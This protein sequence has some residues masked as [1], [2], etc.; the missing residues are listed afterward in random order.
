MKVARMTFADACLRSLMLLTFTVLVAACHRTTTV[1]SPEPHQGEDPLNRVHIALVEKGK[2]ERL[3]VEDIPS[4]A[5]S[6]NPFEA[7]QTDESLREQPREK[8]HPLLKRWLTTR[9]MEEPELILINL[10]DD[11]TVPRFPEPTID[12]P[13]DSAANRKVKAEAGRLIDA[14]KRRRSEGY[15]RFMK[16]VGQRYHAEVLQTFWLVHAMLVKMPLGAVSALAERQDILYIQPAISGEEPPQNANNNDDVDD[17]RAR[18]VSDPYFN[19]GQTGG[20]IGLLDTGMRFTHTQLTSPSHVDFRRDCVNGGANCNTGTTLNPV[21]DCWDHGTSSGAI[22]TA[23]ANQGNVFRGV[24]GITLDSFKVYPTSFD[25]NGLCNGGL[26]AAAA[27][28]GFQTAVAVLDRVIVAEMQSGGTDTGAIS[29]AADNAFDAGAVIIAAN[30]NNGP[31]ASTVNE[32]AIAHKVIGV[33]NFDVQTQ[34]QVASQSRGPAPDNRFKPDIQTPT[35]TET[36]SNGCGWQQN[37]TTGGSNTA[38]RVFGGTSA[39]RRMPPAQRP[40]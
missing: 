9:A 14:L 8:V 17:G 32:P 16:E 4:D 12:E 30:G 2:I 31:N 38:F 37:C 24:T 1:A 19:L 5:F 10:R 22:I 25:A 34:T 18:M 7:K 39:P 28:N 35:N 11:I 40:C 33:G 15:D 13:R 20:W 21:D 23:N 36:A 29:T 6:K 27:V 3:R 26:N